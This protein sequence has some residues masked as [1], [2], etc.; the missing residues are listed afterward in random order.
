MDAQ[1]QAIAAGKEVV[2]IEGRSVL[3]LEAR[4]GEAFGRTVDLLANCRGRVIVS[5]VGKSGVIARKIVATFN[6]T[7]T[8]SV[9]LHPSDAVHGDLGIVRNDDVVLLI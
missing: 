6:S 5:G 3:A 8:P 4:I 1:E 9:F 7:G 2:R